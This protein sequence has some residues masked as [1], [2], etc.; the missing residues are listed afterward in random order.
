MTNLPVIRKDF[1][2]EEYQV[3]EAKVIGADAILLIAAILDDENFKRLYDLAY[4]LGL[5][6]LCEVHD[7][8]ELQRMLALDVEII[9]INN[10]NLKTFEVT[11]D[12]TKKLSAMLP[13]DFK[14]RGKVLVSES[15][16][17]T[18]GDISA[19]KQSHAD[20]FLIGTALMESDNP[21]RLQSTGRKFMQMGKTKVKVCGLTR[22]EEAEML[23]DCRVEF[24]GM[25]LFFPKANAMSPYSRQNKSLR[26]SK[27][28]CIKERCRDGVPDKGTGRTDYAA[29]I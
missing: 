28:R 25:V 22:E 13:K 24:A 9:G 27:I 1:I 2:I 6:V 17:S 3:Y 11:M 8:A 10:R 14:E 7:E 26:H 21:G 5:D 18:D 20:A 4:S 12:T 16:V 19:L 29:G 23:A 15:G